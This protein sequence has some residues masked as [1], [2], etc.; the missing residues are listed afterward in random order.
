M[1][2]RKWKRLRFSDL[3]PQDRASALVEALAEIPVVRGR[4]DGNLLI[5]DPC[6]HCGGRHIHGAAGEGGHRQAHC[7]GVENRGYFLEEV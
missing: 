5:V 4:R 2:K 7:V 1:G 3:A 6:P